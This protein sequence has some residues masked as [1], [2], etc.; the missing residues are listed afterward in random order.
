MTTHTAARTARLNVRLTPDAL[1]NI[2]DAAAAQQQDVSSFVLGA[3]LEKARTVLMEEH[4]LHLS[5]AEVKQLESVLDAEA[6]PVPQLSALLRSV[7][8]RQSVSH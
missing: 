8:E 5:P 7:S 1:A 3:A 4:I 2:R 6:A